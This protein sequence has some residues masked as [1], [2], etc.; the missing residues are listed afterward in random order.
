M[1]IVKVEWID[2]CASNHNWLMKA[3]IDNW[4]DVEPISIFT[5]GALVQEDENY[6]V[7]AQNYGFEPEQCCNLMS[8]PRGCIKQ[9][10]TIEELTYGNNTTAGG[11][12]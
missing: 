1:K 5:Y 2:S 4:G 10:T 9:T 7:V 8:I 3:D 12:G 6:I 11:N